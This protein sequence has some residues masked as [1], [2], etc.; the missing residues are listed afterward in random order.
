ML[1]RSVL[2]NG[3]A[4]KRI[5]R[6]AEADLRGDGRHRVYLQ[7]QQFS[8]IRREDT[9]L[10]DELHGF[11]KVFP[12]TTL[13]KANERLRMLQS[14]FMFCRSV[15]DVLSDADP[16]FSYMP[17]KCFLD[18]FLHLLMKASDEAQQVKWQKY[19]TCWPMA[20]FLRQDSM[21]EIPAG[22]EVAIGS[23]FHFPLRGAA[24]RHFRNL[25]VSRDSEK[26]P[27]QVMWAI[28]QGVKRGCAE[29]PE[30][31]IK[32]SM[33]KHKEALTQT[34]PEMSEEATELVRQK[35]RAI[36]RPKFR[37]GRWN[38]FGTSRQMAQDIESSGNPNFHACKERT[39]THDGRAGL[40]RD[41]LYQH[42]EEEFGLSRN[43]GPGQSKVLFKMQEIAPGE[44]HEEYLDNAL[45]PE[46]AQRLAE[47]WAIEDLELNGGLCDAVV[48]GVLEPLKCRLIT[49]GSGLPYFAA[50]ALQKAMWRRL[51]KFPCFQLTGCPLDASMLE[52]LVMQERSLGL[53]FDQWV[54]GDYSAAT[55]GLSQQVN[56]LCLEEALLGCGA[57]AE[58]KTIARAVLGNHRISYPSE[59]GISSMTQQNGQ[60]MGSPLSFPILCSINV[61][62]YWCALEEYTGRRFE[63]HELPCLV[64]GD[65]I[66]FRANDD[67]YGVWKRWVSQVGFTLSAGKNYIHRSFVTVNSEGYIHQVGSRVPFQKVNF[68][69]TGL[70]YSGRSNERKVD[71]RDNEKDQPKVGLRPENR[72]MPF[73]QKVN[74]V[75]EESCSPSRT[76]KRVHHFFRKEIAH[77]TIGGEINLHGAPELGGLGIVLPKDSDTYFTP[78]QQK[79]AGFLVRQWKDLQFGDTVTDLPGPLT[80]DEMKERIVDLNRPLKA[81]GRI[82]YQLKRKP[83]LS[84]KAPVRPGRIVIREKMEPLR[85]GEE[86]I[87]ADSCSLR[88]YQSLSTSD[89]GEWRIRGLDSE[90]RKAI[91]AFH[92]KVVERPLYWTREIR[93][94]PST[95]IDRMVVEEP[96]L[97]TWVDC[98]GNEH[99]FFQKPVVG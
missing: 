86:R 58:L 83:V 23:N 3:I 69:N 77:H 18:G 97:L 53:H 33:L 74:R 38:C 20:K 5:G 47:R 75:I 46:V 34:L 81:E 10:L 26:R 90:C 16:V 7:T 44:V 24:R 72:E 96:K 95:V 73:T 99:S 84:W 12:P 52:G 41:R 32:Q 78:W 29:V 60:L 67:F 87:V 15:W 57:S 35:F 25:L 54:S 14:S 61:A 70:L 82:T 59:F 85:E 50:M 21:P 19:L 39:R 91:R 17:P 68:L 28:L 80:Q 9:P 36:F 8:N 22:L 51:Q 65:D 89:N 42:M 92:G 1:F 30:S 55:D 64:N 62:A 40:V 37:R 4:V 63:L 93:S 76:L 49:K 88:N 31:F 13:E 66:C 56:R 79:C 98:K 94:A 27:T 11:L 48:C 71:W 45:L 6:N 43:G 2:C